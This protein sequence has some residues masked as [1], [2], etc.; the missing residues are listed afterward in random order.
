M[1][2]EIGYGDEIYGTVE[3]T[4][5]GFKYAGKKAQA[6]QNLLE[7]MSRE[8]MTDQQLLASLPTRLNGRVWAREVK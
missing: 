3:L 1:K 6:V 8:N 7:S 2:L 5:T 4:Q